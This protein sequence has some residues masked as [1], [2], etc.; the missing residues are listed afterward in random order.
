VAVGFGV[1]VGVAVGLGVAVGVAV[2]F[3]V[4]VGVAVGFGVATAVTGGFVAVIVG[5]AVGVTVGV[6]VGV[7]IPAS[8]GTSG[9]P[10]WLT[11]LSDD[12]WEDVT[13]A[14]HELTPL[15]PASVPATT[16]HDKT[17]IVIR[18]PPRCIDSPCDD[19]PTAKARANTPLPSVGASADR[20]TSSWRSP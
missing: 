7:V 16:R 18:A 20:R 4:A 11:D 9:E 8:A 2:G 13:V 12:N 1:A 3:G 19:G 10:T 14:P 15:Q 5:N 6:G 17:V